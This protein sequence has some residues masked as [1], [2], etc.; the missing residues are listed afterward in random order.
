MKSYL[1]TVKQGNGVSLEL[2]L[3]LA[4]IICPP[5]SVRPYSLFNFQGSRDN[6]SSSVLKDNV[7]LL[8]DF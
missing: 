8:Q 6:P 1:E 5:V 4:R 3:P 2:L 7:H